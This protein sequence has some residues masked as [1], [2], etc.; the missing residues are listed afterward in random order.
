MTK[1][2]KATQMKIWKKNVKDGYHF[3]QPQNATKLTP[4][5][6]RQAVGYSYYSDVE[7]ETIWSKILVVFVVCTTLLVILASIGNG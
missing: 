7:N 2:H 4:R 1:I 5:T 6:H 3:F